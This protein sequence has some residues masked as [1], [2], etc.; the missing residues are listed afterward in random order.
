MWDV[1]VQ[2]IRGVTAVAKPAACCQGDFRGPLPDWTRSR[3]PSSVRWKPGQSLSRPRPA[4]PAKP[5]RKRS[6]RCSTP[7]GA[8]H[9]SRPA[10]SAT[11]PRVREVIEMAPCASA[12][13]QL[14]QGDLRGRRKSRRI[15]IGRASVLDQ[16]SAEWICPTHV[17]I[18]SSNVDFI[19]KMDHRR[20]VETVTA[21]SLCRLLAAKANQPSLP[22]CG[23]TWLYQL[24]R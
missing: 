15:T 23:V 18:G 7:R 11:G 6:R 2:D 4:L 8:Y 14:D 19:L 9:A 1:V 3:A 20:A 17:V 22:A 12:T 10:A 16:A 5:T 13:A 21:P 24:R